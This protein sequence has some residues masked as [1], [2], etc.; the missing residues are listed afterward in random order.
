LLAIAKYISAI[1]KQDK[2]KG[3]QT[4]IIVIISDPPEKEEASEEN[5]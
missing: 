3:E 2:A 4:T 1:I 5:K